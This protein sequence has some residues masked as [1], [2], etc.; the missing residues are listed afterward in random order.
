MSTPKSLLFPLLAGTLTALPFTLLGLRLTDLQQ[1]RSLAKSARD[2][3][4]GS[5]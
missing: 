1:S 2:F 5:E 3:S 4:V